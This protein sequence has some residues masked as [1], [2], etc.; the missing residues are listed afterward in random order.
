MP[1]VEAIIKKYLPDK[2]I[3]SK[4]DIEKFNKKK[5]QGL[6]KHNLADIKAKPKKKNKLDKKK[7]KP[8]I[9]KHSQMD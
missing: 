7:K 8:D 4:N 1:N 5:F 2:N 9:L 3:L 6:I